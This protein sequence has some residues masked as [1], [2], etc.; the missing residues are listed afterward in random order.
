MPWHYHVDAEHG[1]LITTMTGSISYTE[2][3]THIIQERADGH[4]GRPEL[5]LGTKAQAAFSPA[6]VRDLV[7]F[8]RGIAVD[9]PFGPT[10]VVVEGDYNY[11]MLRMLE[12]LVEDVTPIRVF[13]ERRGAEAWLA[14]ANSGHRR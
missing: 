14:A 4:L 8:I 9:K 12:M 1:W 13:R 6:E 5:V 2:I 10:A 7:Q 3:R 11:G